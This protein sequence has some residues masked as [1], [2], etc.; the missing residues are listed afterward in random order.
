M[1]LEQ[2]TADPR[3]RNLAIL[4]AAALLSLL[5]AVGAVWEQA[6]VNAGPPAPTEF[7]PGFARKVASVARIHIASKSGAFDVVFRPEKGWV[8]RQRDDYPANYDLVQR[9]RV[10]LAALETIEPKT[11]RPDWLHYVGLD[12]P[13]NGDGTL[14][15]LSDDKG[16]VLAAIIAGKSEDIGDPAGATGLFVRRPG[17][18]QSWLVRSVLDPRASLSDWLD[19]HVVDVDRAE[20]QEADVDPAGSPSYVLARAKPSDPDFALTPLPGGKPLGDPAAPDGVAAALADFGFDDVAPA[21]DFDFNDPAASARIVTKTFD[22]LQVTARILKRGAEYWAT[23]SAEAPAP[24]TADAAAKATQIN[25][26]AAGW[27]YKL[28]AYKGQLF[29]T[30]LDSLTKPPPAPAPLPGQP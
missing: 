4:G 9:T 18:N 21:R 24:A 19:K 15:A 29:M 14:I 26:H 8:V 5:L 28:P 7:L 1:T 12:A 27:A 20:I 10:G 22:G 30:T 6:V 25:M 11:A 23:L 3:R 17:E 2:L 16:R 13:P